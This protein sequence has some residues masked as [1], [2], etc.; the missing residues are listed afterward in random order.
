MSQD[1]KHNLTITRLLNAPLAKVWQAWTDP[2][3]L[4][5]WWGPRGVTNPV[6]TWEAEAGGQIDIVMLAGEELGELKGSEW[7]MNGQFKEVVPQKKLI[8]SSQ[9]LADGKP[10]L[11][12]LCTVTFKKQGDKT[13]MTLSVV[14]TKVTPE[15]E[16]PLAGMKM[17]WTQSIDKLEEFLN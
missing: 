10:I 4:Q 16:G 7:P 11:E 17:G 5:K 3:S 1:S 14:V 12:N 15:A 13:E 9:A 8:F 6:C 2:A